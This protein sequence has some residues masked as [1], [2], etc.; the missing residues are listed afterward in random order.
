MLGNMD[1][2]VSEAVFGSKRPKVV[3][4]V[5]GSQREADCVDVVIFGDKSAVRF[6][7]V[8]ADPPQRVAE[9]RI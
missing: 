8:E 7:D 2:G 5:S 4:W 3:Q 6:R 1:L 9:V